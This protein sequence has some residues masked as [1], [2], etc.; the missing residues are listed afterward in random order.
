MTVQTILVTGGTGKTGRRIVQCL[1]DR[2]VAVRVGSRSAT[3]AF[4]WQL[5]AAWRPALDGVDAVYIAYQPDLAVP[6]ATQI[7]QKFVDTAVQCGVKRLVLLSGR[8]EPEAQVCEK[9]VANAGAEWTVIRASFFNQNFSEGFLLEAIQRGEVILPTVTVREPFIDVDDIADIA[10]V[11]LTET[12]HHGE[13]YEVTGSRLLT[14]EDAINEIAQAIDKPIQ[15]VSVPMAAYKDGMRQAGLDD[16]YLWLMDYLF[17]TVLDGRNAQLADGV[18]RALGRD[19]RDFSDYV[20]QVAQTDIWQAS[21]RTI[22]EQ[23]Q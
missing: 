14:F 17:T 7:I 3:P 9:I 15:Y 12:G 13:I 2:D 18:Q 20:R 10:T 1:Q 5:D 8:G 19:P 21:V 16:N 22:I 11:A 4:D 23:K 6:G